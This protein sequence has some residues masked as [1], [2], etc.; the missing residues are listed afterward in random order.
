MLGVVL[1]VFIL[2]A[3]ITVHEFGHYLA[4]KLLKFKI[5]EFSIGFGPAIF[6][7]KRKD[8]DEVFAIRL[9]P[10]GGYCSFD[11]ESGLEEEE[12]KSK[13]PKKA[14]DG[15]P[16]SEDEP[17][18][19]LRETP[20]GEGGGEAAQEAQG[21][22]N[23]SSAGEISPKE[24]ASA[25]PKEGET[26]ARQESEP[27]K[28]DDGGAFT[29]KKPWQ[30]IIVLISGALM[31]YLLALVLILILIGGFGQSLIRVRGVDILDSYEREEQVD[32]PAKFSFREGDIL[33]TANGKN[34][35]LTTDI[36]QALNGKKKGD[37]VKFRVAREE[38]GRR[39]V[40]EQEI[41]LRSDVSVKNSTQITGVWKA[42]G[43]GVE[44]RE[45]GDYYMLESTSC[46]FGFFETIGRSFVYSF[47]IAGSIFRVIGELLTGKLGLS[48]FGGPVTTI[49]MTSQIA[50]TSVRNFLEISA[51]I[52]VNLAVFN[53]L[54]IPA[55]DGSKVVFTLIEWVRGKP[56]S[57]KVEAIIH[58]VGFVLLLGFAILV[59][60]LQFI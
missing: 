38:D 26:E 56:I 57:R 30:R 11:G 60:I 5:N 24:E 25:A 2:L 45:D 52:G 44:T 54:P 13:K 23:P 36:A 10:L 50:G 49:T 55:L 48:A 42:I 19:E 32:V 28:K 40:V 35:Y 7:H 14:K 12:K 59:D 58:A 9:I 6:K 31:N 37:I 47:K 15:A 4:G 43:V 39:T 22:E 20:A 8:S 21:G 34:L 3:M 51:Y 17:F 46:R 18:A 1:A 53:L 29:K 27:T 16:M 33:L 41:E